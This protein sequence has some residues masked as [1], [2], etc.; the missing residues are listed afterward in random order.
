MS[1]EN[2]A[3][4]DVPRCGDSGGWSDTADRPCR[5]QVSEEGERCPQH[6]RPESGKEPAPAG[7]PKIELTEEHI[8]RVETLAGFGLTQEEI[9]QLLPIAAS[10][11]RDRPP[12]IREE[13]ADA[14]ERGRAK[15]RARAAGRYHQIAHDRGSGLGLQD[16]EHV[17][18]PQQRKALE[19]ILG[20]DLSMVPKE[21]LE[22][23]GKDGGPVETADRTQREWEEKLRSLLEAGEIDDE[24]LDTLSRVGDLLPVVSANGSG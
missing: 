14:Y 11:F 13:F 3:E 1:K 16:G 20:T 2:G 9:F 8:D 4:D 18:I 23:T 17:P 6:P 12:G 21:R 10:T 5:R 15:A 19:K 24:D 22:I 7:R